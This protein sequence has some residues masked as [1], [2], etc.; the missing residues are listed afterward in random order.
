MSEVRQLI[1][2]EEVFVRYPSD[3][4]YLEYTK[5]TPLNNMETNNLIKTWAK[6]L[7]VCEKRNTNGQLT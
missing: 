3:R 4:K 6:E 5:K 7:T 1:E 2:L